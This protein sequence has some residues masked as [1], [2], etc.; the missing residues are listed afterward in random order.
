VL[1]FSFFARFANVASRTMFSF[2]ACP[3]QCVVQRG[4]LLPHL[5]NYNLASLVVYQLENYP[6]KDLF[7]R[8]PLIPCAETLQF[9]IVGGVP[10]GKLPSK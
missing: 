2:G 4:L 9:G 8:G 5:K 6:A 10:V 1:F 3:V 7:K